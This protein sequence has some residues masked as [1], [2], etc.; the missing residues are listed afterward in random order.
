MIKRTVLEN[1]LK[2]ITEN[3]ESVH[4]S[5]VGIWCGVGS[6][7]E[8]AEQSG[9]SHV[10]EHMFF[11]GTPTRTTKQ[12]SNG[13]ENTG[14]N[15]NAWTDKE[16]TFYYATT[17]GTKTIDVLDILAD[18]F[19]NSNYDDKELGK[20]KKIIFEEIAMC[21]DDPTNVLFGQLYQSLWKNHTLG[22]P[23]AGTRET[24]SSFSGSDL[25][26]FAKNN[27]S[28]DSTVICASGKI[29]HESIEKYIRKN[30]SHLTGSKNSWMNR[31]IP[32]N[33]NASCQIIKKDIE[34]V[35]VA[36]ALPSCNNTDPKRYATELLCDILGGGMSSRLF[37]EIREKRGISY[38]V[39]CFNKT[40]TKSGVFGCYAETNKEN[41]E[42]VIK[43]FRAELKK[44]KNK[45]VSLKELERVK[46]QATG[47][48]VISQENMLSK[49][50]CHGKQELIFGRQI[51]LEETIKNCNK[52]SQIDILN[53]ANEL[54]DQENDHLV[55]SGNV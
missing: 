11:K 29:D 18:S 47:S 43:I 28:P 21:E 24:V 46:N 34:Q 3:I 37:T 52:V 31:T 27:Y 53:V 6:V 30:F 14:G 13:I 16:Q 40:H 54:F 9:I 23:I 45:K 44:L 32:I 22:T 55:A 25:K 38:S 36:L 15:P 33:T 10:T 51:P 8:T 49:I 19:L 2:L 26:N 41:Y 50:I 42:Q 12:I 4:S 1:G 17:L 5:A 35:H 7:D 48:M 20:E 39:S